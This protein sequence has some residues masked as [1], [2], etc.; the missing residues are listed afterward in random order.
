MPMAAL[1]AIFSA[2]GITGVY[3]SSLLVGFQVTTRAFGL[4]ITGFT[5]WSDRTRPVIVYYDFSSSKHGSMTQSVKYSIT[6]WNCSWLYIKIEGHP[7]VNIAD[8]AQTFILL[9]GQRGSLLKYYN[10]AS[11]SPCPFWP[12]VIQIFVQWAASVLLKATITN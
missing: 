9:F 1:L 7:F 6:M 8:L 3:S 2:R 12:N 4:F 11:R 5:L 10:S